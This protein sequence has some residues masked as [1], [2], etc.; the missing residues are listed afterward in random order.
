MV[1]VLRSTVQCDV[2]VGH[3]HA[4]FFEIETVRRWYM[5][6]FLSQC[7]CRDGH[8]IQY[9]SH[10]IDLRRGRAG[11]IDDYRCVYLFTTGE[12]DSL[13]FSAVNQDVD[14]GRAEIKA[15]STGF[16]CRGQILG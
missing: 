4:I 10:R 6:H 15:R 14:N 8:I 2:A 5:H 13:G 11:D 3:H 16:R 12:H 1:A 7:S 9:A